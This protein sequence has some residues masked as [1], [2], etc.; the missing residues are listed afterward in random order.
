MIQKYRASA[1][2]KADRVTR[3]SDRTYAVDMFAGGSAV[4]FIFSRVCSHIAKKY[5]P[6]TVEILCCRKYH[7]CPFSDTL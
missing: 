2:Q 3:V 5:T 6:N 7:V 1:G 4:R